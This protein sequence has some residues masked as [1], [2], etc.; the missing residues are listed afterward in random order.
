MVMIKKVKIIMMKTMMIK[1]IMTLI[2]TIVR[3]M[4]IRE[5]TTLI[6]MIVEKVVLVAL[7]LVVA[8]I[9]P[10]LVMVM[11]DLVMLARNTCITKRNQRRKVPIKKWRFKTIHSLLMGMSTSMPL[12]QSF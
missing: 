4:E 2:M 3:R 7:C 12:M 9:Q 11:A 10:L 5:A 6:E 8:M 1:T